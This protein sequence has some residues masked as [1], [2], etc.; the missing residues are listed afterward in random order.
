LK[1]VDDK[2]IHIALWPRR[3]DIDQA[4]ITRQRHLL[5]RRTAKETRIRVSLI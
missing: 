5:R 2:E 1:P 4:L 3:L